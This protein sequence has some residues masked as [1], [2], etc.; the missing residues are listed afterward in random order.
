[1]NSR[2]SPAG[3]SKNESPSSA[4]RF[5]ARPTKQTFVSLAYYGKRSE[6]IS[7]LKRDASSSVHE[8]GSINAD[9]KR[10]PS[11]PSCRFREG[12]LAF[13]IRSLRVSQNAL[14]R[15]LKGYVTRSIMETPLKTARYCSPGVLLKAWYIR[16]YGVC[17]GDAIVFI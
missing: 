6:F 11:V 3:C 17:R 2:P 9:V 13:V 5:G 16:V 7:D 4:R 8:K 10:R 1:M 14:K 12:V 15:R